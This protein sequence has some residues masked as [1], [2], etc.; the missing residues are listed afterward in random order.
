MRFPKR[1]FKSVV[2][3]ALKQGD[4]DVEVRCLGERHDNDPRWPKH[5]WARSVR[6]LEKQWIEIEDRNRLGFDIH[7]T[8]LPRVPKFHGKKEHPLPERLI[9]SCIWAD[10]DVGEGKP[11]KCAIDAL[12]RIRDIKPQP[13]IFVESGT[14]L[15][16]YWLV[17]I[18]EVPKERLERLLRVIAEK[19]DGDSG[20]A[21]AG[22]LMRVPNTVNWKGGGRG[23]LTEAHFGS[24][25]RYRFKELERLW[26]V[27]EG[28]TVK[29]DESH[30]ARY[31]KLFADNLSGFN[32]SGNSAE[33][34]ALCPF[35]PD[36]GP[37]FAVNL[38]SGLWMCWAESC[39]AKGNVEQFCDRLQ[40]LL[41]GE[42]RL[43]GFSFHSGKK[44]PRPKLS[45]RALYGLAGDIVRAIEPH[46]EAD[47]VAILAQLLVA[48]GN[49]IGP[50]PYFEIEATKHRANL[51]CII[52]GRSS[53]SRKGTS[54]AHV[55]R[56]FNQVDRRWCDEQI[57]TGLSSGEGLIWAARD[58]EKPK[59]TGEKAQSEDDFVTIVDKRFMVIQSEFSRV[60]RVQRREGN[61]LSSILRSSWDS[62]TLSVLTK[63]APAKATG[64]YVS[65]I[66]H[67][68]KDELCRELRATDEANGYANR[69]LFVYAERTKCLPFGGRVDEQTI[70]ELAQRLKLARD[71][72]R[73][74][75]KMRFSKKA[76]KL[77]RKLYVSLTKETP[78]MLGAI[79]SRAEAQVLRLSII[80]ALLSRSK[81][82]K[83]QHLKAAAAFWDY[84]EQSAA[85]IFGGALGNPIADKIWRELQ[86]K[87]EGLTRD[88]I[89][90]LFHH[91]R[92]KEEIDEALSLLAN[93][94]LAK[95]RREHTKGRAAERWT[96]A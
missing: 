48:F 32:R 90:E 63:N 81:R 12:R 7:Y 57:I 92:D 42:L 62:D 89:R 56:I 75:D 95:P 79:T 80:Y 76:R 34:T 85:F 72:A 82:I 84:G 54:L 58:P 67:I 8:V 21:R 51:F 6:E 49:C 37:S 35:H 64:A 24:S 5:Y 13:N 53:R 10:L 36:R 44:Q 39:R 15:H 23:R 26:N 41:P 47:P 50:R 96:A 46:T 86:R 17:E 3:S 59:R 43:D 20:A 18:R 40:I 30:A 33:A 77:W 29:R 1:F 14:G 2:G 45:K 25:T 52:V 60:L 68:T 83:T 38:I 93:S 71:F 9:V 22:R 16:L 28:G 55:R 88:E 65:I 78:G 94:G 31:F 87:K 73:S 61:T 69:F 4:L 91:N 11:Y 27:N 74:T 66:G 70:A 19:L